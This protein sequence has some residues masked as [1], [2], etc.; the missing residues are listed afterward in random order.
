[1]QDERCQAKEAKATIK[2]KGN[3]T[4]RRQRSGERFN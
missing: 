4:Q 3:F 1:M 2:V